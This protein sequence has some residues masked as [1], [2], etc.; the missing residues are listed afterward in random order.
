MGCMSSTSSSGTG[1]LLHSC[2]QQFR[3]RSNIKSPT[4]SPLIDTAPPA[5][6]SPLPPSIL[7][8]C[9]D[10]EL[11]KAH[12]TAPLP[13]NIIPEQNSETEL[14]SLIRSLRKTFRHFHTGQIIGSG[15]FG[16]VNEI[17][18]WEHTA[19]TF[20]DAD[21]GWVVLR[22][23]LESPLPQP[24]PQTLGH[25]EGT[26]VPP[27]AHVLGH[28][29]LK[30]LCKHDVLQ[31]PTGLANLRLE[32]SILV[33]LREQSYTHPLTQGGRGNMTRGC[34]SPTSA[35]CSGL[36]CEGKAAT[37]TE[38]PGAVTATATGS[39]G[40]ERTTHCLAV[41]TCGAAFIC[42][43]HCAFQDARFVYMVLDLAERGGNWSGLAALHCTAPPPIRGICTIQG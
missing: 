24:L 39:A 10:S 8:P 32:L 25:A 27:G 16:I 6:G 15:G 41:P 7:L 19:N 40:R 43:M 36:S 34:G 30:T 14:K 29:A 12:P 28:F 9:E 13:D 35:Q 11:V 3:R 2:C 23:S 18:V 26:T 4:L 20:T 42:H 1:S 5:P 22:A 38:A 33:R 17:I 21:G 37:T 31:R